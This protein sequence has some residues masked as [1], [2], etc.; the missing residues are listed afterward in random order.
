MIEETYREL[1]KRG[2]FKIIDDGTCSEELSK[3]LSSDT[4]THSKETPQ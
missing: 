4:Q 1:R 3:I 2:H